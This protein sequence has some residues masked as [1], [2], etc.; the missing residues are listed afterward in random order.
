VEF[1]CE[2]TSLGE[3]WKGLR[4][5]NKVKYYKITKHSNRHTMIM[6]MRGFKARTEGGNRQ[7]KRNSAINSHAFPKRGQDRPK[8]KGECSRWSFNVVSMVILRKKQLIRS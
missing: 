5:Y 4:S 1:K 3:L 6:Q 2:P 8:K 7:R